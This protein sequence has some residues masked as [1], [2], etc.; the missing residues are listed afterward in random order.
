VKLLSVVHEADAAAGVFAEAAAERGDELIEWVP[1]SG[2]PPP[3][4]FD[5]VMVFGGSMNVDQEGSHPWLAPE[6]ELLRGLLRDGVPTLGVCLGAQLLAEAAGA[7][8]RRAENP[9]I[10]WYDIELTAAAGEDPVFGAL[11]EHFVGFQWHGFEF[12]L[13][14][15]AVA[16][17]RSPA[18]LQAYRAGEAAWGI[19]F[20]A[21]VT[22]DSIAAWLAESDDDEDRRRRGVDPERLLAESD[23]RIGAWNELGR[24]LSARFLEAAAARD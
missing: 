14:P 17:A 2:T 19:Q 21:E 20:H 22:L 16:L 9:E 15:G 13:P 12:P 23:R 6:K 5:A 10:G 18:C 4:D 11:P 8:P 3:D 24:E 7:R 1:P